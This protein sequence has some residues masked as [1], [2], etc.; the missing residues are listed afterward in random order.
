MMVVDMLEELGHSISV[1]AE[2][3]RTGFTVCAVDRL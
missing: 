1:E 2:P 3:S